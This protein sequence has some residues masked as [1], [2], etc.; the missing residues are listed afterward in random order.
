MKDRI[1]YR[2]AIETS[3]CLE[4]V[5][6]PRG[7]TPTSA[8]SSA[9]GSPPGQ[10]VHCQFINSVGVANSLRARINCREIRRT[11]RAPSS[12]VTRRR[13][14]KRYAHLARLKSSSSLDP[15]PG[16]T[17]IAAPCVIVTR[18]TNENTPSPH[19]PRGGSGREA[20]SFSSSRLQKLM[21]HYKHESATNDHRHGSSQG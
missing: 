11:L 21:L 15:W 2:Q 6:S 19:N 7:T 4:R 8:P 16:Q 5:C 14:A 17:S 9:L 18:H 10:A 20:F 1:L 12:C 13:Q 3:R